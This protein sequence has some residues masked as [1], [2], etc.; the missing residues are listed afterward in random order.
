MELFRGWSGYPVFAQAL[1]EFPRFEVYLAG[2]LLRNL[3]LDPH[4]QARDLD[5]FVGGPCVEA[6]DWLRQRGRARVGV[7]D[8]VKWYP[9]A[10]EPVY[11]DFIRLSR[12]RP[13]RPSEDMVGA[14]RQFDFTGNAIAIDVRTG[15]VLDPVNGVADMRNR[16]MRVVS[17]DRTE[18]PIAPGHALSDAVCVWFR[19][20][21]FAAK[22]GLRIEPV[23]L[24]WLR[25]HRHYA[26]YREAFARQFREPH[27]DAFRA[28]EEGAELRQAV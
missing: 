3:L 15:E 26:E 7:Y 9:H 24:G 8:N 22:L 16:L 5:L 1:D 2:G 21:N 13:V 25:A 18:E 28:L 23:T 19:A 12:F 20:L 4:A 11:A 17:F 14:L 10:D 27:P 6:I